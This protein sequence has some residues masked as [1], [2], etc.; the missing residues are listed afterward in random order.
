[1]KKRKS[2]QIKLSDSVQTM[3]GW[4]TKLS[5]V[6]HMRTGTSSEECVSEIRDC[7][8]HAELPKREDKLS[9]AVSVVS[10]RV[11]RGLRLYRY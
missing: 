6:N 1:M 8:D 5:N 11:G 9:V 10:L 7:A 2:E 4:G 3:E